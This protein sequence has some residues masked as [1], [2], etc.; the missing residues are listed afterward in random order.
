MSRLQLRTPAVLRRRPFH[1]RRAVAHDAPMEYSTKPVAPRWLVIGT[2]ILGAGVLVEIL[3][4][5]AVL[6]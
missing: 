1:A 5:L 4:G 6:A 2:G 3:I